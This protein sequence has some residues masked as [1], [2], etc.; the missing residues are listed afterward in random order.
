MLLYTHA[1]RARSARFP[2]RVLVHTRA[3][4]PCVLAAWLCAR[5]V[6]D[7]VWQRDIPHSVV[8]S[9]GKRGAL[10]LL[11]A[12]CGEGTLFVVCAPPHRPLRSAFPL[13][14]FLLRSS[15]IC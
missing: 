6:A 15:C 3:L 11:A 8:R 13:C 9:Y 2:P 7:A 1:P 5:A 10:V 4:G 12:G 14:M